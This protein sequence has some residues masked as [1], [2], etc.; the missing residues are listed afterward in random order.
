M[1]TIQTHRYAVLLFKVER[2]WTELDYG[3]EMLKMNKEMVEIYTVDTVC[4]I[5]NKTINQ[6]F[7]TLVQIIE[8][9]SDPKII[10]N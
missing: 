10:K 8:T 1:M 6:L 5:R 4:Q 9:S 7:W 2:K 3:Q